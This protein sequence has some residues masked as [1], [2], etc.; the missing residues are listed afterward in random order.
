MNTLTLSFLGKFQCTYQDCPIT[1]FRSDKIRALLAY[2]AVEADTPH[3]RETL[4]A[5]F[6][7]ESTHSV[8]LRNLRKSLHRLRQTLD[9]AAPELSAAVLT[10]TRQTVQLNKTAVSIDSHIFEH[11]L[12]TV[13]TH[14]HHSLATCADCLALLGEA[15][16]LYQGDLLV[17]LTLP[18]AVLFEEWLL[19]KREFLHQKV[20]SVLHTVAVAY[21]RRGD[22][23][24]MYGYAKRQTALEPWR[25]EAHR[26]LMRA[27]ARRGERSRALAQY[28]L[29]REVLLAELGVT[30]SPKTAVL[31]EQIKQGTFPD[32]AEQ[33]A[34][35]FHH[36]PIQFTTFVGRD[37][38]ITA[39]VDHLL[40][41]DCRL[42]TI[43]GSG[44]MG[45]TRLSVEA[46]HH[47]INNHA[48]AAGDLFPDGCYFVPL[49]D[50]ND[51]EQIVTT[52]A[53]ALQ[54]T[55]QPME[56]PE[57]QLFNYLAGKKLLLVLDNFEQ[58]VEKTAVFITQLLQS[59]TNVQLLISSR[60]ALHTQAEW[61]L[62]L[63]GLAYPSADET[64]ADLTMYGAMRLFTQAAHRVHP[65]FRPDKTALAAI[66]R[67]CQLTQ[68][69]PLA[70][71]IAA[72][73]V[74]MMDCAAIAEQIG[75]NF[76]FLKATVRDMPDRHRSMRVVFE[77]SWQYLSPTAQVTLAQLSLFHGGFDLEAALAVMDDAMHELP[78]LLDKSLLR[79]GK[80]G[81]YELHELL[82]QFAAEKLAASD[83]AVTDKTLRRH[84]IYYLHL[85]ADYNSIF[86]KSNTA[87]NRKAAQTEIDNIRQAWEWAVA[88][89]QWASIAD[90]VDGL[91]LFYQTYGLPQE[92]MSMF[93]A[94][95]LQ[96]EASIEREDGNSLYTDRETETAVY[97]LNQLRLCQIQILL[98]QSTYPEVTEL[99]QTVIESCQQ[100]SDKQQLAAAFVE[101]GHAYW[102]LG[103]FEKA[104]H[105]L[106][107]GLTLAKQLNLS[108]QAAY[109]L[110]CLGNIATGKKESNRAHHLL[111][112]A[113]TLYEEVDNLRDLAT[114]LTDFA[115]AS[116]INGQPDLAQLYY[117]RS[118]TLHQEVNNMA[119]AI[120]PLTA[121]SLLALEQ[122]DS[123]ALK[124]HEEEMSLL[125]ERSGSAW[126][127]SRMTVNLGHISLMRGDYITAINRFGDGLKTTSDFYDQMSI[128]YGLT[129]IIAAMGNMKLAAQL[130][131]VTDPAQIYNPF[132]MK[133][134]ELLYS[135]IRSGLTDAEWKTAVS[136]GSTMTLDENL[137]LAM[138]FVDQGLEENLL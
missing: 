116:I 32:A 30:P 126:L 38:E 137:S 103:D 111:Q 67:I 47:L 3:R 93:N 24:Q 83:G 129:A 57:Q 29:C 109:A 63:G 59:A 105:H 15:T 19:V 51:Q 78:G 98:M 9:A 52:I 95:A 37:A 94:A 90:A 119:G 43:I 96:L 75:R 114:A 20:L 56:N 99:A 138:A 39:V 86:S 118:A 60:E 25:E 100:S 61:R 42:L 53:K 81:R 73:W 35:S 127:F 107:A 123:E 104:D 120:D 79:R 17:G 22:F 45:K 102:R 88:N 2:L 124:Q 69:V 49:A 62:A 97:A 44:G 134:Y 89:R 26:Q 74:R 16:D 5:L 8:A 91:S 48:H 132:A 4:A 87:V 68:G 41:P 130:F 27:L 64:F 108:H 65:D 28:E 13:E 113:I 122:G 18:D 136:I 77:Q 21:E 133:F 1:T 101:S 46:A 71:E 58:L 115:S 128:L 11:A 33:T 106:T 54:L 55:F 82:R 131:F 92:G 7:P 34:V 121:L 10:I 6:W 76:D 85:I 112:E 50:A 23:E 40:N 110:H 36:F 125:A 84:S 72:A 117:R 12:L 66:A 135:M 31:Y 70:L 80:N 14:T